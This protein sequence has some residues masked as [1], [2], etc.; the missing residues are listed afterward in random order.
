MKRTALFITLGVAFVVVSLWYALSAGRSQR[1]TRLKY[2]LGGALLSLLAIT[3]TGCGKVF[4]SC[5]VPA[6]PTPPMVNQTN[7]TVRLVGMGDIHCTDIITVSNGHQFTF[8]F[9]TDTE[10]VPLFFVQ[11]GEY[12]NSEFIQISLGEGEGNTRVFTLDVGDFVGKAY[13]FAGWTSTDD[14]PVN[15]TLKQQCILN[16]VTSEEN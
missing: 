15:C 10:Y 8:E 7:F 12:T 9:E 11:T 2:R 5:Y 4:T 6:E 14:Q 3:S 1:A 16:V 13:L